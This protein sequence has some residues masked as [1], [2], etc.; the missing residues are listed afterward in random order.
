MD[1]SLFIAHR[2]KFRNRIASL[3]VAVSFLVMII[4][5]AISSG[6]RHEIR[7]S[8]SDLSGDIQLTSADVN[9]TGDTSPIEKTPSYIERLN[10][11]SGVESIEP[12]VYRGGI[13]KS[14][15]NIHGVMF[16]GTERDSTLEGLGISVPR[17]LASLLRISAGDKLTAYFVGEKVKT[18]KFTVRSIYDSMIDTDDNLLIYASLSDMQRINGWSRESVSALEIHLQPGR[19]DE[20]SV[21]AAAEEAGMAALAFAGEDEASVVASSSMS[22][23]PQLY[24]WLNLIDFNVFFVLLLMTAVAGFNMISGL[25]IM[26]FENIPVIGILKSMGMKD[27]AISKTFLSAASSAVLKGMAGGNL[28]AFI[29]CLVQSLTHVLKLDPD[30]YFVSFVPVH[31]D[32]LQ[33][34]AADVAA[35]AVIMLLLLLPSL[36]ISGVDPARTVRVG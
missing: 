21:R 6:F 22:R 25:L 27:R 17:R 36:F 12:C 33:I 26:L 5:V 10:S 35:Y 11:I 15:D 4:A 1:V 32:V 30:N 13:V 31:L 9:W 8:I 23:Y 18:R 29:L 7:D 24:D 19:R 28:I 3:A 16:K 2:I 20:K 14:G 34:L